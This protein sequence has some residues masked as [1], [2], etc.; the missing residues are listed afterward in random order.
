MKSKIL[1]LF[2]ILNLSAFS[3]SINY[4]DVAV[5]VNDSS[6]TSIDIAN[7][8]QTLRNIPSQNMIH[9]S[10]PLTEEIDSLQFEQ[11]RLQ[12]ENYLI[13]ND[14]QDSINYLVTTK[15]VPLKVESGCFDPM[16]SGDACA[17]FDS[18]LTLILGPNS[19]QIGLNGSIANPLYN[20]SGHFSHLNS[21]MYLVT[22]L[23]AYTTQ[24]VFDLLD[25]SGPLTGL[26]QQS[27]QAI[28]DLNAATGGDSTYFMDFYLMPTYNFLINNSWN[29]QIDPNINP[30][31]NQGNVFSYLFEGHGPLTNVDLNYSWTYAS[32]GA[33]SSCET[34]S[35]FNSSSNISNDFL[36]ADLIA[37]GCTGAHGNVDCIFFSQLLNSETL[38]SRYLDPLINYN[39]AESFYMAEPRLSWQ[40]VIIGD[41][42]TSIIISDEAG[43]SNPTLK[44]LHV[45]PNP[46]N[47]MIHINGNELITSI[48]VVD[49]TGAMV[50]QHDN[51]SGTSMQLNLEGFGKGIYILYVEMGDSTIQERIVIQ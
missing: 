11:I 28:I 24:D 3:Q 5:I 13:T 29:A 25:R 44:S 18:E 2:S 23:D 47:G 31:L 45:F 7:Y 22:R 21:G 1:F 40:A 41:P 35:T 9:I 50:Q 36:V 38:M 10:A 42:K 15:G 39:L 16:V 20:A 32:I 33:L 8:F 34:A 4:N 43:F 51:L 49:M 30:L 17:S 6:Q 48:T 12:I 27:A 37:E 26:N 46:S 14:L 19:N